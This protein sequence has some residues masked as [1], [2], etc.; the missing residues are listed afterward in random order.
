MNVIRRQ[1][2]TLRRLRRS[3]RPC[4][5]DASRRPTPFAL[6]LVLA[7]ITAE[8]YLQWIRDPDPPAGT[9]LTL[10]SVQATPPGDRIELQLLAHGEPPSHRAAAA[11]T[12]F[13]ITPEVIG[14]HRT[15]LPAP[16][17]ATTRATNHEETD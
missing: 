12:G 1:N 9:E 6:T 3:E 16:A 11:A 5:G 17:D 4:D 15:P 8:D 14:I 2:L 13:P 10:I 7:G